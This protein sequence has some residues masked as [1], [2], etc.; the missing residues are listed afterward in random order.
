M[1]YACGRQTFTT[2][3]NFQ[4]VKNC[5][6]I[7]MNRDKAEKYARTESFRFLVCKNTS[8]ILV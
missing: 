4:A 1:N 8:T 6:F 7:P 2:K 3:P 5:D